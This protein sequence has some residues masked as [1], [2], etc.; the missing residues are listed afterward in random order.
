MAILTATA[1]AEDIA[2]GMGAAVLAATPHR[3]TAILG[4]CIGVS[5]YCPKLHLG[6]LSHVVLPS[7]KGCATHPAKYADTAV[8]HMCSVLES[9][10]VPSRGMVAKI[11]GGA[12]MFGNSVS[13]QIGEANVQATVAA[14]QSAGVPLA[15]RD[16]GG[17]IGRRIVFD[18]SSGSLT[19]ESVGGRPRTL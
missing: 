19:V 3:L 15:A 16:V 9:R 4:S 2:V 7:S 12:C 8:A 1:P 13:M 6:M 11:A 17:V 14:L 10:G 5:V 18:L